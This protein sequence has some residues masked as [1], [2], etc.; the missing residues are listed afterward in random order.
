MHS[1]CFDIIS[2]KFVQVNCLAAIIGECY[3]KASYLVQSAGELSGVRQNTFHM[4]DRI[5]CLLAERFLMHQ[6][7]PSSLLFSHS[8]LRRCCITR[9]TKPHIYSFYL[10]ESETHWAKRLRSLDLTLRPI[11]R[12]LP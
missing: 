3:E 5:P 6:T 2:V 9:I 1:L 7:V 10:I 8:A 12:I 4:N 11:K